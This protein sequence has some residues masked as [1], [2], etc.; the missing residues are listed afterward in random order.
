MDVGHGI[1]WPPEVLASLSG[2]F[3]DSF[4]NVVDLLD[5]LFEAA[6]TA[7]EPAEMNYQ[8]PQPTPFRYY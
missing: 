5:A 8:A 1:R 7:D 6:A 4:A 2:I 3:R